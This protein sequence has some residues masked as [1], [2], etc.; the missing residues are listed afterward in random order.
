MV[1]P[2][3]P[4]QN[5]CTTMC[6][7]ILGSEGQ[8][9][10]SYQQEVAAI[11]RIGQGACDRAGVT[12]SPRNPFKFIRKLTK[13][14]FSERAK[15]RDFPCAFF[16]AVV[17]LCDMKWGSV[18]LCDKRLWGGLSEEQRTKPWTQRSLF[19]HE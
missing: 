16:N 7:Q 12:V 11:A 5:N 8:G 6:T 17:Q 3:R 10:A 13:L 19:Y 1:A 15:F 4:S 9:A 14:S 2:D 18:F